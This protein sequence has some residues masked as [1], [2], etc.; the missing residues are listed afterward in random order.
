MNQEASLL[1]TFKELES[2]NMAS[3][4]PNGIIHGEEKRLPM[5]A[6]VKTNQVTPLFPLFPSIVRALENE[7][8]KSLIIDGTGE[9]YCLHLLNTDGEQESVTTVTAQEIANTRPIPG[10][11][12]KNPIAQYFMAYYLLRFYLLGGT[13]KYAIS[14]LDE[15]FAVFAN[16][17]ENPSVWAKHKVVV[18][19]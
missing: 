10:K 8:V 1:E 2:E 17:P 6:E 9:Y 14:K 13:V 4:D 18:T 12:L 15:G 11:D 16:D 3:M 5:D 7:S 19:L